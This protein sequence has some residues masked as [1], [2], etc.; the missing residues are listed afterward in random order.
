ME[1]DPRG[2]ERGAPHHPRA[3][4]H[5][6]LLRGAVERVPDRHEHRQPLRPGHLHHLAGLGRALRPHIERDR[7]VRR[8]RRCRGRRH[9]AGPHGCAPELAL[10]GRA[11]RRHGGLRGHRCSPGPP[12]HE[13]QDPF[14]RGHP[15]RTAGLAGGPDLRVRRRQGCRR[16]GDLDLQQRH[17]RPRERQHEP[18]GGLDPLD[19]DGRPLRDVHALERGPTPVPGSHRATTQHHAAQRGSGRRGR[20][21]AGVGLQPE[22]GNRD[23]AE[24]GALGH[25]CGR[26]HPARVVVPAGADA[27]SGA[28]SMPSV[29]A[30]RPLAEPAST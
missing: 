8:V 9:R 14:V 6:H 26:R 17:R 20:R 3:H 7:P 12:H 18:G 19:R 29:P 28:T 23:P 30:P 2:R 22:P 4:R 25:P 16:R 27:D 15:G 10:V 1:E 5:L 21:G 11:D 13:A 24:R